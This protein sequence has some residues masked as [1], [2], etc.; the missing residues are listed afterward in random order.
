MGG[1]YGDIDSRADFERVLK[2][3]RA[4]T[5]GMLKVQPNNPVIETIDTQLDAMERW[6]AAGRE[7]TEDERKTISV[8][9]I[10]VRELDAARRDESGE[11]ANKLYELD[12]YFKEWPTDGQAANATDADY[13][14]RFGL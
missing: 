9:L 3:A 4:I 10:A 7:P 14:A 8:G 12:N 11:L 5:H 13:W 2:E 6:T 1:L